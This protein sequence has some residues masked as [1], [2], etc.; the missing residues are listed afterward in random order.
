MRATRIALLLAV[1]AAC[2]GDGKTKGQPA[3]SVDGFL[4]GLK[5]AGLEPGPLAA[6]DAPGLD[7]KC[8]RGDVAGVELTVCEYDDASRAKKH[9]PDGLALV[10]EATGSSLAEGKLLIVVADRGNVDKDGKR[11][12]TITRTFRGR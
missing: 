8:Q 5:K 11:I 10:G 4:A 9:E 1:V 3:S 2:G 12:D 7:A 6:V